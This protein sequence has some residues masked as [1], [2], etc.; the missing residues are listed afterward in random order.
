MSP[1]PRASR[2]VVAAVLVLVL[3]FVAESRA[4]VMPGGILLQHRGRSMPRVPLKPVIIDSSEE[5]GMLTK[6]LKALAATDLDYDGHRTKAVAHISAAIHHLEIAGQQGKS[7]ASIND[8]ATGKAPV[9]TKTATTPREASDESLRAAK[10]ILF[11]A[12][13]KLA[14]HAATKGQLHADADVRIAIS[15]LVEALKPPKPATAAASP[16]PAPAAKPA[17]PT[18]TATSPFKPAR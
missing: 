2:I 12:H 10:A 8:A 13:H 4:A 14:D 18:T 5:I 16:A 11:K 15:E 9:A 17:K 7:N 6:A 1:S 3:G